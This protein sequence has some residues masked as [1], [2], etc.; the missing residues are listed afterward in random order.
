M[1]SQ[2][3]SDVVESLARR[4]KD[5]KARGE[6]VHHA[7]PDVQ[8][9][10]IATLFKAPAV[11]EKNLVFSDVHQHRRKSRQVAEER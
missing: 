1:L 7:L 9:G 2:E 6:N 3:A 5:G 11:V 10:R 8:L 4:S